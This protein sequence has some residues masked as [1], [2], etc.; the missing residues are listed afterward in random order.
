MEFGVEGYSFVFLFRERVLRW[1]KERGKTKVI[2]RSIE[3]YSY[4]KGIIR[5]V[6]RFKDRLSYVNRRRFVIVSI[7]V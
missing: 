3:I 2:R 4:E 7:S 6:F 1:F 5:L